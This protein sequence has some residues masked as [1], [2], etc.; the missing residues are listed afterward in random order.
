MNIE[1]KT[2]YLLK[3]LKVGDVISIGPFKS[4]KSGRHFDQK[5]IVIRGFYKRSPKVNDWTKTTCNETRKKT[6]DLLLS[7]DNDNI[8]SSKE[9]DYFKDYS[10]FGVLFDMKD[11][12][13]NQCIVSTIDSQLR[14]L[15]FKHVQV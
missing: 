10:L 3:K 12:P 4:H 11:D 14:H 2:K 8:E 7:Y 15:N 1:E 9:L 5:Q 13:N 6:M